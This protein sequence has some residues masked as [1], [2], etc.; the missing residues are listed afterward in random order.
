MK[1]VLSHFRQVHG[2]T[3]VSEDDLNTV[4]GGD[5]DFIMQLLSGHLSP[6]FGNLGEGSITIGLTSKVHQTRFIANFLR[7]YLSSDELLVFYLLLLI[8]FV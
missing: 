7:N 2:E 6:L 4:R 3:S 1:P 8:K 5:K